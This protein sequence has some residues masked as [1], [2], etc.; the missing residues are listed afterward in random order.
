MALKLPGLLLLLLLGAH[1]HTPCRGLGALQVFGAVASLVLRAHHLPEFTEL[2]ACLRH[3]AIWPILGALYRAYGTGP[4]PA[5]L[6]I[7][8]EAR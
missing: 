4:W 6:G 7:L 5:Q 3:V 8:M 1:R 2:L